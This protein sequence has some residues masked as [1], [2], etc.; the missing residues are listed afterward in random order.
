M[1][2][3]KVNNLQDTSGNVLDRVAQI[4]AKSS[5]SQFSTTS[6]S[7][8]AISSDLNITMTPVS[9]ASKILLLFSTTGQVNSGRARWDCFYS[10]SGATLSGANA[11]CSFEG[12]NINH[13]VSW[14]FMHTHGA[15]AQIVYTPQY[16]NDSS[17]NTQCGS[18][19]ITT[20]TAIE[21][22]Q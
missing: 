19:N 2:T 4:V 15:S 11:M 20:F 7:Y 16:H 6:N 22:L 9:S 8:V 1:S 17:A 10:A 13:A 5:T 3:L 21:I 18:A 12:A 14:S